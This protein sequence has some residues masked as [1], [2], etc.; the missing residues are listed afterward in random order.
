MEAAEL[1]GVVVRHRQGRYIE[2]V[3]ASTAQVRWLLRWRGDCHA[4]HYA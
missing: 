1:I 3:R 4:I 2:H